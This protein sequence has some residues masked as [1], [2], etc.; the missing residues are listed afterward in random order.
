MLS[1]SAWFFPDVEGFIR[2]LFL[3]SSSGQSPCAFWIDV[4]SHLVSFLIN[5]GIHLILFRFPLTANK[6]SSKRHVPKWGAAVSRPMASST[7]DLGSAAWGVVY[8]YIFNLY[9]LFAS[10]IRTSCIFK[11]T[12][13][14]GYFEMFWRNATFNN[15]NKTIFK[16]IKHRD[17]L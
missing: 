3:Y 17:F 16:H 1:T 7:I 10:E 2:D 9:G 8:K 12:E 15:Q 11:Q 5:S 13:C 14:C 4:G 6:Q